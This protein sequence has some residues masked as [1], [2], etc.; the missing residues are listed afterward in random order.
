[1]LFLL[2]YVTLHYVTDDAH[3]TRTVVVK[4]EKC[5]C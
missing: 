1:M 3:V 2:R 4:T 5:L